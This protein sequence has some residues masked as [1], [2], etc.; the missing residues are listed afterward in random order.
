MPIADSTSA[1]PANS[2]SSSSENRR[3][4][5]ASARTLVHRHHAEDRLL[6]DPRSRIA[7]RDRG[8]ERVGVA[9]RCG[10][11]TPSPGPGSAGWRDRSPRAAA[12]RARPAH[13][14]GH[15][16]DRR[17]RA[18]ADRTACTRRPIGSSLGPVLVRHRPVDHDLDGAG[19]VD[20][21]RERASPQRSGSASSGSS[22]A[23]PA[24]TRP[25]AAADRAAS[26]GPRSRSALS[27]RPAIR[28]PADQRHLHG[29]RAR[30]ATASRRRS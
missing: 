30:C 11:R 14:A 20:H 13:V 26:A 8:A 25:P 1:S 6:A 22:P 21:R 24:G 2:V 4:A 9:R 17:H 16:D 28:Q 15:A 27:P 12:G 3:S 7:A 5:L 29:R 10:R 19:R 23:S 18:L